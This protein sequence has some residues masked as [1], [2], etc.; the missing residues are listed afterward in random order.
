MIK[1]IFGF[2]SKKQKTRL[3][4]IVIKQ[5]LNLP[6]SLKTIFIF[7]NITLYKK[8]SLFLSY[9]LLLDFLSS[10]KFTITKFSTLVTKCFQK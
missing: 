5:I 1:N 10:N 6:F 9:I 7:V 3:K 2:Y 4:K 8:L